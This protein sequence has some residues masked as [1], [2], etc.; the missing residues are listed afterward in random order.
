MGKGDNQSAGKMNVLLY[1][2]DEADAQNKW[3]FDIV[4]EEHVL[5][6]LRPCLVVVV[7]VKKLLE[8]KSGEVKKH[9]A[10]RKG[11]NNSAALKTNQ[12]PEIFIPPIV[13]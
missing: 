10:P 1:I 12:L 9:L 2:H 7:R 8:D 13:A 3:L 6:K 5:K 11:I 4:K